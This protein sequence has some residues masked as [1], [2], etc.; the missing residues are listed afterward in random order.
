MERMRSQDGVYWGG[1]FLISGRQNERRKKLQKLNTTK[2]LDGRRSIFCHATTNQKHA[3]MMEGG[4]YRP[5]DRA[6]LLGEHDGN[7]APLA[8]GNKDN[9]VEYG[10]DG[11]I[12]DEDNKYTVCI[13]G[14]GEPLD[15]GEDQRCL[16]TSVPYESAAERALTL[17]ASYSQWVALRASYSQRRLLRV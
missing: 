8:E 16:R 6:R 14:V 17:I 1:V 10:K 2:A 12:P 5:R 13:D 7:A 4:W 11:N 3:G 9:N 15:E